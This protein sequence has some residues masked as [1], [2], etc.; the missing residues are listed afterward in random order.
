MKSP[1]APPGVPWVSP[2]PTYVAG[3]LDTPAESTEHEQTPAEEAGVQVTP[4]PVEREPVPRDSNKSGSSGD[5]EAEDHGDR[6]LCEDAVHGTS[7][8]Q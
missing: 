4:E 1:Q 2:M 7:R 3:V 8:R 6:V 5:T